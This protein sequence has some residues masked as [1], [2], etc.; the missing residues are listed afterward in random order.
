MTEL[1]T[2]LQDSMIWVEG[3]AALI[4]ILYY[5]RIKNQYWKYF[6]YYLILMFLCEAIGKWGENFIDYSKPNFYN[7]F[8][9]PVEFIFFYWIYAAKSFGKPKLFYVISALYLISLIFGDI[10]STKKIIMS[11]SYTFGCLILMGLVIMEYYKQINSSNILNFSRNPM[12][13]INLGV[14]L[15]YIGT[16]PF[17]TFF[18]YIIVY[19]EIYHIYFSYFL[20]SGIVMYLLFSIS[21]IW[22]KQNS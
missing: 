18:A 1:E 19:R 3:I 5:S 6:S 9:I 8:V 20:L 17:W 4:S 15:F 22:G 16:L 10:F 14:T 21:F 13:Y 12:F 2:I 7:Y 11:F